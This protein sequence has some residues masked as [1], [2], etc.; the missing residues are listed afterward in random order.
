MDTGFRRHDELNTDSLDDDRIY[1][2]INDHLPAL[3]IDGLRLFQRC[4]RDVY[5]R[6]SAAVLIDFSAVYEL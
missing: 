2:M 4:V 6:V 3:Q 1:G 5:I